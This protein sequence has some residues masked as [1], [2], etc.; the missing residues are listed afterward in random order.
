MKQ[1]GF[2]DDPNF[3][4]PTIEPV[5]D[6]QRLHFQLAQVFELMKDGKWRTLGAI[7]RETG[8]PA[9]SVSARLRDL[10]K[11]KFGGHTVNREYV[12]EGL[13]RYQLILNSGCCRCDKHGGRDAAA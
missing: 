8:A 13:Y 10:R 12:G 5:R 6:N 4:G 2:W 1:M 9:P 11:Q 3:D 7:E